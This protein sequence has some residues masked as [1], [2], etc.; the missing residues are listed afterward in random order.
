MEDS[1]PITTQKRVRRRAL[2]D[3][4]RGTVNAVLRPLADWEGKL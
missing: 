4:S 2:V 3:V 1:G